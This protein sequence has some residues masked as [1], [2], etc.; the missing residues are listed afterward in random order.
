M[1]YLSQTAILYYRWQNTWLTFRSIM[2]N[3][4]MQDDL[5]SL[6]GW[7]GKKQLKKVQQAYIRKRHCLEE[8]L[9]TYQVRNRGLVTFCEFLLTAYKQIKPVPK[10]YKRDC[11]A[12]Y[13]L[14]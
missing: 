7:A 3:L 9:W 2:T 1:K 11:A 12:Q 8:R 4:A 6:I 14:T 5:T 13:R 10:Y